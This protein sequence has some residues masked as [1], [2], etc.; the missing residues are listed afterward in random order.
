MTIDLRTPSVG[1]L[2]EVIESLADWQLDELPVQLHSGDLGW[3]HRF[4]AEATAAA[5][6]TWH[7]AGELLAIGL[8]DSPGVLRL[9]V[10][11]AAG[12]DDA[13]AGRMADDLT[14]PGRG[15]LPEGDAVVEV[16]F[17]A[18]LR[19]AL[20]EA[21]WT[22]DEGWTP[23]TMALGGPVEEAALDVRVVT[24]GELVSART[25][26]QRA[27]FDRSTFTDER[28]RA[29]S[30]T[31]AYA[32]A[33]C[34]VGFDEGGSAVAAV[35]VWSAGVGRRGLIEPLGVHPDHRGR[36]HGRAMTLAAAVAL[37]GMGASSVCVATRAANAGAVA[38]Y[39]SAGM[40]RHPDVPDLRRPSA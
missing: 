27:A 33:R 30:T 39:A 28:W 8:L 24:G 11:P 18:A 34:L 20:A 4:G 31:A 16:R 29:M 15:L 37:R 13:L 14:D 17:G 6:R 12:E 5:V 2:D 36:G 38:T 35:T 25:A 22:D 40:L 23:L 19:A 21:G 10:S 7:R 26:V 32:D 9:A 1:E 3:N